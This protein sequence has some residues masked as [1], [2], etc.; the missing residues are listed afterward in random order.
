[1]GHTK[2]ICVLVGGA[3]VFQEVITPRIA[4][5]MSLA[6]LGM[7]GYGYFTHREKLAASEA[8]AAVKADAAKDARGEDEETNPLMGKL[9]KSG[10]SAA[11]KL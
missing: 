11:I 6:V 3:L 7:V 8:Q 4:A 10:S 9:G 5:G 2:T 1:M